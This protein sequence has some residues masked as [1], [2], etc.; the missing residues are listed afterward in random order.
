MLHILRRRAADAAMAK[1]TEGMEA[2]EY[3][4]ARPAQGRWDA[5]WQ[6]VGN[7]PTALVLA[8]N[9]FGQ[10]P[11]IGNHMLDAAPGQTLAAAYDAVV[12]L[13]PLEQLHQTALVGEIYTPAFKKELARRYRFLYTPEQ[14]QT[15][16]MQEGVGTLEALINKRFAGAGE[17]LLPQL[18]D[19]EP[20]D[21]WRKGTSR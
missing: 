10:A 17:Q 19:L 3:R 5:A 1:T 11:Y 4:W 21:A 13:K 14:L 6:L 7:H 15:H 12:F 20:S 9:V 18:K 2:I 16:R 8:G